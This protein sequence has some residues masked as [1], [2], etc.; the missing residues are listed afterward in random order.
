MN[1]TTYFSEKVEIII[2]SKK[3]INESDVVINSNTKY[4]LMGNNGVGKTTLLKY[5][6][7]KIKDKY[8][9][10]MLDQ[11]IEIESDNQTINEFILEANNELYN[12]YKIMK[13]LETYE[14]LN[15]IQNSLY[16]SVSNYVYQNKWDSYEAESK[17]ILHGLG[18]NNINS[19]VSLLSGGWRMRLA[20]GKALLRSP[21][22]LF[23][24]EPT[25]HLDL[26]AVIW[27][28]DYLSGYK[29]S[30]VVITHQ[31]GLV[32]N[33]A[34]YTWFIGDLDYNG[35]KLYSIKGDY[36]KYLKTKEQLSKEANQKYEKF[37]KRIDEFKKK[38]TPKK[39][40][41]EFKK[42]NNIQR[43][44]KPYVVNIEFENINNFNS[45]NIIQLIDINFKYNDNKIIYNNINF[46]IGL[47]SRYIIVGDNGSGKTTL[48][49]LCSGSLVPN[50]GTLLKDDRIKVSYYNQHIIENLPL[51]MTPIEY[52]QN[53]C[54]EMNLSEILGKFGKIGLKKI[55]NHDPCRTEI[56]KLSGGQKARVALC[57][58]QIEK[59]HIILMDEPT[60]HLD[61]ESI[62]GLIK[63]INN[64]N[65]GV[66][67]I[68]HDLYLINSIKNAKIC[69]VKDNDI[70]KYKGDFEDYYNMCLGV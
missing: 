9:V 31:I 50:S 61:I 4:F 15:D 34:D 66:L 38:S 2:N 13:L 70:K 20:L 40:V 64:F 10:L 33:V 52:L 30:L 67:L 1:L 48:F 59:P 36:D 43:P 29:K 55:D 7:N 54:P 56:S 58:L 35:V 24:D 53:I 5:I 45:K 26:E 23:L 19:N 11:D 21:Q 12:N 22:I 62:D 28:S 25:N 68:T 69:I 18:F 37:E 44:P 41:D 63:G 51:N 47:N 60:N 32:N 49:K 27:L 46:S 17:K 65:G 57:A 8:D 14:E 6:Y 3:I 39:D 42:K 16:E